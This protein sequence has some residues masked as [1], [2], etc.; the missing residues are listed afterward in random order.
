M[1]GLDLRGLQLQL[2]K[3]DFKPLYVL[4]SEDPFLQDEA[5]SALKAKVL[6]NGVSE[7]NY[8]C[9]YASEDKMA[10]VL[11]TL[12]TLP[13]MSKHRLVLLKEA[14][15]LHDKEWEE[16]LPFIQ[17]PLESACLVLVTD[18]IDRR[19]K[20]F[21]LLAENFPVVELKRPYDNQ[22]PMWIEYI[23]AKH[24]LKLAH[25]S[26]ALIRQYI[27]ANLSEIYNELGKI[28][29]FIGDRKTVEPHDVLQV[30]SRSRVESIFELANAIGRGD[31]ST[32]L[33][34]LAQILE[35]GQNEVGALAMIARHFRILSELKEHAGQGM[36]GQKLSGKVGI[37]H[38]FLQEYMNQ[39][40][41][42]SPQKLEKTHL[43]LRDTDR[44]LKSSPLSS[45]IWLENFIVKVCGSPTQSNYLY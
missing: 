1:A 18:K 12:Q 21:K 27:G 34:T 5:I 24:G 15:Q 38:F 20:T 43:A 41:N 35:G 19:K 4:I 36:T 40:K 9:F 10:S 6:E 8:D 14:Q 37:A 7:F 29:D 2:Y 33:V 28:K 23:A 30:V 11:D 25:E 39:L 32:A 31:R 26:Q 16:L 42:W 44:A 13:M 3:G 17:E 22:L 45:H